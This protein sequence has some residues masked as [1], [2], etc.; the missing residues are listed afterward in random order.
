MQSE[1]CV[2]HVWSTSPGHLPQTGNGFPV[3][4]TNKC[5]VAYYALCCE[6]MAVDQTGLLIWM[7]KR[8]TASFVALKRAK[9][10]VGETKAM[11]ALNNN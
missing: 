2:G 7:H 1:I 4:D 10:M 8:A 11:K 9:K 3:Y 6:A 5:Q